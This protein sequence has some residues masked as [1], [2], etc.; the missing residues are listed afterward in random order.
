[1]NARAGMRRG[2]FGSADEHFPGF[3]DFYRR[4]FKSVVGLAFVLSGNHAL[5]EDVAQ[6]A[7]IAAH[8]RW[9]DISSYDNPGAW[10]RRVVAN[11]AASAARRRMAEAKALL[12][13]GSRRQEVMAPLPAEHVECWAAVRELPKRQAQVVALHYLEGW[14]YAEISEALGCAEAT[15]RVHLHRA[16]AKLA[17]RLGLDNEEDR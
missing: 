7:F 13:L 6:N 15:V 14:T 2:S 11:M 9:D 10:V 5:A 3:D 4:E 12:R 16:H 8:R 17:D 1:M